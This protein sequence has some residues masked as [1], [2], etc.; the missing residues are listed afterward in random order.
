MFVVED[1]GVLVLLANWY[2]FLHRLVT[3]NLGPLTSWYDSWVL[4][5]RLLTRLLA[6]VLDS[7]NNLIGTSDGLLPGAML[8]S[9]A[10][11]SDGKFDGIVLGQW[12]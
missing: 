6:L 9:I 8:G 5:I 2:I 1:S 12:I 11:V 7:S 3:G 4:Y 10:G